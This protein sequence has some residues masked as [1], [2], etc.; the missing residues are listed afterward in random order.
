MTALNSH[1]PR[2]LQLAQTLINEI[3]S[4]R[5]EI[6]ALLPTEISLCE[7]FG[8]SRFTVREAIKQL[9]NLGMVTR[10]AGVGTRVISTRRSTSYRQVMQ[11]L[12]DLY[13]Y[14]SDTELHILSS[15]MAEPSLDQR[16]MMD[17]PAGQQWLR[18]EAVRRVRNT[19]APPIC[20]TEILLHP[21]FRA[22]SGLK[23][24][25]S[26]P[27]F[28]L[29]EEEFGEPI[30]E[31]RQQIRAVPMDPQ[32]AKLINAKPRTPALWVSRAYVNRRGEVVELAT[33][34]HPADRFQYSQ[35]FRPDR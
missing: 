8:A 7:Q 30:I 28:N 29:I 6:G 31:V 25:S 21:A 17:V 16:E 15:A 35:T 22:L 2:Y 20:F 32:V 18:L 26:R 3:Q 12:P 24:R 14:S 33:S 1:Q 23:E 5:Y 13:Q 9:V 11:G 10:Q 19:K 34:I 4:G 27:V